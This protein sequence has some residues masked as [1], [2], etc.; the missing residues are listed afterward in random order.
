MITGSEHFT[1]E[2]FKAGTAHQQEGISQPDLGKPN[3]DTEGKR[4]THELPSTE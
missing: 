2:H 4:R 1:S 3:K